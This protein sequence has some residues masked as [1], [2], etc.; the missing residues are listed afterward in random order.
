ME[1]TAKGFGIIPYKDGG[2]C[3]HPCIEVTGGLERRVSHQEFIY[4]A[5]DCEGDGGWFWWSSLERIAPATE[6]SVAA[7]A[8]TQ[9]LTWDQR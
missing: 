1:L 6:V 7:F 4:L 8:I 5:P 9:G 2:H 3:T